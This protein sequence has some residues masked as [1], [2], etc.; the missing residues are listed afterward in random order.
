MKVADAIA[1]A[2]YFLF[3]LFLFHQ[4]VVKFEVIV[5][6]NQEN[7]EAH[8]VEDVPEVVDLVEQRD[9]QDHQ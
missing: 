2:S 3:P 9:R 7:L 8:E 6:E 1:H 4:Q 5:V